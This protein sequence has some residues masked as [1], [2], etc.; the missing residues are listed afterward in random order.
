MPAL[1]LTL[2]QSA[3]V[4]FLGKLLGATVTERVFAKLFFSLADYLAASSANHLD[5]EMVASIR[6]AYDG[7]KG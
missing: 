7:E 1:L 3:G 4:A 2:L 5:D 6:A